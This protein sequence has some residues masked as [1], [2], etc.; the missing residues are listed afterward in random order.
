MEKRAGKMWLHVSSSNRGI[1]W[2]DK[3]GIP[4]LDELKKAESND[5]V[6]LLGDS[7]ESDALVSPWFMNQGGGQIE[8]LSEEAVEG[9]LRREGLPARMG[10]ADANAKRLT[11]AVWGLDA[12]EVRNVYVESGKLKGIKYGDKL[13]Q[14]NELSKEHTLWKPAER[15][16]VRALYIL[17]L[18]FGQVDLLLSDQGKLVITGLTPRLNRLA[19]HG[20]RQLGEAVRL[21]AEQW[22]AETRAGVRATLGADPEFVLLTPAGTIVPASRYFAPD[23][24]AGCDSIRIQGERRWPLVELRPR[25]SREPAAVVADVRRLLTVASLRTAGEP[26]TWRAGAAPIAG[27]PLGGHVHLSGMALTSERLRALDNAVALPLRLLEPAAA[28]KRRPRYGALGDVRRQPHGGFEYRTPPSWLVSPRLALGVLALAKLAAEHSRELSVQ[29][30]LDDEQYRDAF[31]NGDRTLLLE[32]VEKQFGMIS[33]TTGYRAYQQHI[34]FIF[35]AINRG[36]SWDETTD[37]RVK[38]HIPIR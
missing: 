32:A 34:D 29:R 4:L 24:A 33:R 20:V 1:P 13:S 27:L 23:G 26:F 35:N 16:A 8:R 17:G 6:M 31:Y 38:W 12:L 37:I 19:E 21:S 3:L 18:D 36:R 14:R 28:G 9:R 15:L 30:P 7:M 22:A 10:F 25:P 2:L 11:V 5:C